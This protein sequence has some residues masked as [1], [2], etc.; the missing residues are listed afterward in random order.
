MKKI[1]SENNIPSASYTE[2]SNAMEVN[3]EKI[4]YPIVV[5]PADRSAARGV[6]KVTDPS[7]F[8]AAFHIA[9]SESHSGKV[10]IEECLEGRQYSVETVTSRGVHHIVGI[11][12]ETFDDTVNFI[13]TRHM[14]PAIL[15]HE[16]SRQII[17][18]AIQTL[19]A[20]GVRFGAGH[21]ELKMTSD[22]PKIIEVA[23]R[24]GGLRDFMVKR[25]LGCDYNRMV[26]ESSL[27][28]KICVKYSE[29]KYI[30]SVFLIR[31]SDYRLYEKIKREAPDKI[32]RETNIKGFDF[33]SI[34][35]TLMDSQGL[36][37]MLFER[38]E[39][40]QAIIRGEL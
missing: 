12:E 6:T 19:N 23:T 29:Q 11:T 15:H 32:V 20:L 33:S 28:E 1:L 24:T 25:A 31:P 40:A 9:S 5:K 35:K 4:D 14:L 34:P 10:L 18:T 7:G 2:T 17:E 26:V 37:Y 30:V 16:D 21:I 38:P 8:L 22:G 36:F 13:E 39:E 27:G 3:A